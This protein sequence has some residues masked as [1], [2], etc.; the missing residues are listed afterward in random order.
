MF[1]SSYFNRG[2]DGSTSCAAEFCVDVAVELVKLSPFICSKKLGAVMRKVSTAR[3]H[4]KK[5]ENKSRDVKRLGAREE[6][7]SNLG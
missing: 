2:H 7:S 3:I 5:F 1:Y 4:R 6:E